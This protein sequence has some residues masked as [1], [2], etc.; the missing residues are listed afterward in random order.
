MLMKILTLQSQ[1]HCQ[2]GLTHLTVEN[3][4]L[5]CSVALVICERHYSV[6]E[7][8]VAMFFLCVYFF[9]TSLYP[10]KSNCWY[11]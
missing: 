10:F 6:W 5:Q 9:S 7:M 2:V 4:Q 8:A 11:K 3:V 1:V